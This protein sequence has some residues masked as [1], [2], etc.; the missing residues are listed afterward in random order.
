MTNLRASIDPLV[1][2]VMQMAEWKVRPEIGG[3]RWLVIGPSGSVTEVETGGLA[4]E[5]GTKLAQENHGQLVI[6]GLDGRVQASQDFR[7]H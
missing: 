3:Q 7:L 6:Y 2:E 4:I 5:L 1:A